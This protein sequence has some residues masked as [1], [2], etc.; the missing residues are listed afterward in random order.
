MKLTTDIARNLE[1]PSG[2]TGDKK[3]DHIEWDEDFPGFGIRLR[4]GRDR[5][6]RMWIYQYDIAGRTRRHTIGNAN[7]IGIEA[8]HKTAGQLQ[9]QVRLGRD[10]VGEKAESLA[11]AAN[12]FAAVMENYLVVAKVKQRPSTFNR[13]NNHLRMS[14]A[15]LHPLP[16]ATITRRDIAAVLTPITVRGTLPLHNNVRAKL[17]AFF[18]WG[19]SE[20]LIEHNPVVGTVRHERKYRERVLSLPELTA[21]WHALDDIPLTVRSMPEFTNIMRVLMLTGQRKSEIANLP[22]CEVRENE[23]FIDDGVTIIGP[24]IVLPPERSKN[25]RKH[26]VP[27]S[28]PAQFIVLRHPRGP[29]DEFVLRRKS[30]IA[31]GVCKVALDF[32]LI[33]RGHKLAPWVLHDLRRSVATHMGEKGIQPHVIEMVLNHVSGFRAGVAGV[34][35]RAN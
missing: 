16:F 12:T 29:D 19:V 2:K 26:I 24:A 17:S 3:T 33:A 13:T 6:S 25:G 10:P 27:L 9:S 31:W 22:W 11:R 15:Q 35:S 5:V 7:A 20:G 8:A 18:N 21:I 28:K 32:A 34:L 14:A 4:A 30:Q 1:L 23:T